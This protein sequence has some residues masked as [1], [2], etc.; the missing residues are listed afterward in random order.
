MTLLFWGEHT[1]P[2]RLLR[3]D[4]PRGLNAGRWLEM[5]WC[6]FRDPKQREIAKEKNVLVAL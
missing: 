2:L 6:E 5:G 3:L 1:P 4:T